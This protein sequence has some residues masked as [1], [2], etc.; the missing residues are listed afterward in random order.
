MLAI[1]SH[2]VWFEL[3]HD[4]EV[5][6][7]EFLEGIESLCKYV[8]E[9]TEEVTDLFNRYMMKENVRMTINLPNKGY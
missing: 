4:D 1:D 2:K 7:E 9:N 8:K 5:T 6:E 3:N